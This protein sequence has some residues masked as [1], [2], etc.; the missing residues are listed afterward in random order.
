MTV[1]KAKSGMWYLVINQTLVKGKW[2]ITA[3]EARRYGD[4]LWPFEYLEMLEFLR[5]LVLSQEAQ[6]AQG[7]QG[8]QEDQDAQGI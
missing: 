3:E 2:F 4:Q 6:D 5:P 8:T 1:K 7:N